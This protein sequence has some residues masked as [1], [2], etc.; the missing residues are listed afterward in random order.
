MTD[1]A[2]IPPEVRAKL[3]NLKLFPMTSFDEEMIATLN[4]KKAALDA[5]LRPAA[6]EEPRS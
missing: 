1:R 4:R 2:S 3:G 5:A 6:T